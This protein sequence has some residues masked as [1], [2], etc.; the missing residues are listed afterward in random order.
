[1]KDQFTNEELMT[2][3]RRF[4]SNAAGIGA[5]GIAV[6]TP[7]AAF[8]FHVE[9]VAEN[10]GVAYVL[11]DAEREIGAALL[12]KAFVPYLGEWIGTRTGEDTG[13]PDPV[14][15]KKRYSMF[16]GGPQFV[17]DVEAIRGGVTVFRAAKVYAYSPSRDTLLTYFFEGGGNT[18]IF[19]LD[20]Q[21]SVLEETVDDPG[22]L[23]WNE[24]LRTGRLFRA[25]MT[26]PRTGEW[27]SNIFH[28]DE[29]G[30]YQL[31]ATNI[32]RREWKES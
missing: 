31:F 21:A 24:I 25:E 16:V 29:T 8:G 30:I 13:T 32:L 12:R 6:G 1:M 7:V 17:G 10:T 14:L 15:L 18:H 11:S 9:Q 20:R 19:E 27:S 28:Q 4:V 3:R 2:T 23:I 22:K 26:I 5:A